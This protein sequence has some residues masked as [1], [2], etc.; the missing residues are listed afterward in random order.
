VSAKVLAGAAEAR[1]AAEGNLKTIA[2]TGQ[3]FPKATQSLPAELQ[4]LSPLDYM[5]A[6]R[7]EAMGNR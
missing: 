5:A 7:G 3:A 2:E 1:Q 6:V 4:R